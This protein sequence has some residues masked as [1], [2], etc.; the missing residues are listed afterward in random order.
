[1]P[2]N[3]TKITSYQLKSIETVR[4]VRF[5]PIEWTPETGLVTASLKINRKNILEKFKK[6]VDEMYDELAKQ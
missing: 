3:C 2:E 6:E 4:N 5:S 1:V